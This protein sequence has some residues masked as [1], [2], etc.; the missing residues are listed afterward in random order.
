MPIYGQIVV[1]P[2]GSGKTTYCNGMQQ[3]L[4][5]VGR[6][7]ALVVN[8]DPANESTAAGSAAG[9][10]ACSGGS[11]GEEEKVSNNEG[12]DKAIGGDKD[13]NANEDGNDKEQVALPY[14]T[15]LDVCEEVVNLSSVMDEL[16]LGPNG[17]LM[18]CMEYIEHH[19]DHVVDL[20]KSRLQPTTYLLLDL[21]GQ[22]ELYTHCTCVQ[23]I[24]NRLTK[25]LDLRLCMVNLIDAHY[26]A[27]ASKFISAAL[28]STTTMLRLEL[29]AVNV[30]S[31]IDMI[32]QYGEL[33][34]NLDYFTECHELERLVPFLDGA[35][36][37][38]GGGSGNDNED[39]DDFDVPSWYDDPEYVRARSKTRR[40]RFFRK[41]K[42]MHELLSEVVDDYGLLRY[43]PLDIT[44]A[45]SVGRVVAQ[46]DRA[47][48]Y[49]FVSSSSGSKGGGSGNDDGDN[50]SSPDQQDEVTNMFQCA[51]QAEG[52]GWGYEQLA[53]VQEK[54]MGMFK[55]SIT[56][57]QRQEHEE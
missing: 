10:D 8:L 57:L 9:P 48:G 44:D 43:V 4:R 56:E 19:L 29:P 46:V 20:M 28:L 50:A 55:E 37:I 11:G 33:P 2:P 32:S 3:Y 41:R 36:G 49:V 53:D 21:P 52:V 14:D 13:A 15:L 17:G 5:L 12:S 6:T 31:K 1:G 42:R 51:I 23:N 7:D 26:C 47:N 25:D 22:V 40:S 45:A 38:F 24:L 30:L 35:G 16:G 34:Y 39:G 18:Y 54:F 27:D